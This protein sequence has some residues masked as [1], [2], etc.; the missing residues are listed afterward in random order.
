[1]VEAELVLPVTI[2]NPDVHEVRILRAPGGLAGV[3]G[4]AGPSSRRLGLGVKVRGM[5]RAGA[6]VTDAAARRAFYEW[7]YSAD[8]VTWTVIPSLIVVVLC[9]VAFLL[10]RR[11][12]SDRSD[13]EFP[14]R[15]RFVG[16]FSYS[17]T[18]CKCSRIPC[19]RPP[20]MLAEFLP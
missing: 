16:L 5:S 1:M 11:R 19:H 3:E 10:E 2:G 17:E 9:L 7:Q 14:R 12:R 4:R 18:S 13:R 20:A 8:Q 6:R 15:T